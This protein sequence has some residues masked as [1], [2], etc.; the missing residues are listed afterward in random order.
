[1]NAADSNHSIINLQFTKYTVNIFNVPSLVYSLKKRN[2]IREM[3]MR[4]ENVNV[5]RE[6]YQRQFFFLQFC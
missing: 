3:P 5:I 4:I 2:E 6:I 1:M